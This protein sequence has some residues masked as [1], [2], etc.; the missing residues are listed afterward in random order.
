MSGTAS[1]DPPEPTGSKLPDGTAAKRAQRRAQWLD[2]M[3]DHLLA[4][5]LAGSPLRALA[6]A[7]GTSDRMLLYYFSDRDDLLAALLRHVAQRMTDMLAGFSGPLTAAQ[8]LAQLWDA[9]PRRRRAAP[10]ALAPA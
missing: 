8:M 7:A 10:R 3:A 1:T 4:H 9:A 5:G 6:A 2:A